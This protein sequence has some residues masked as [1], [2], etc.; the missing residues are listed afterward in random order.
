MSPPPLA[1]RVFR[2]LGLLYGTMFA[3]Q[4]CLLLTS[5]GLV[6]WGQG[7][8]VAALA[9]PGLRVLAPVLVAVVLLA[10]RALA[11]RRYSRARQRRLLTAQLNGYQLGAVIQLA[12]VNGA[13]GF[14]LVVYLLT[15]S[16]A[17]LLLYAAV[18]VRYVWLR[19]SP[20]QARRVLGLSPAQLPNP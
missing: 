4:A 5:V 18:L 19:P 8:P 15:H 12:M 11:Q 16:A 7:A 3:F 6:R 1:A 17:E 10:A 13:A 14:A 20:A 9:V 2:S